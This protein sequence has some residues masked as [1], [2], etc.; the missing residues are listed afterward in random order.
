M[1]SGPTDRSVL[2]AITRERGKRD[3]D[4]DEESPGLEGITGQGSS[5]EGKESPKQAKPAKEGQ[6][7]GKMWLFW[8]QGQRTGFLVLHG[9]P[10]SYSPVNVT[11]GSEEGE[12]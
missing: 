4:S 10:L 11:P 2:V 8:A 6:T 9:P 1:P 5:Q 7:G 12:G 3:G